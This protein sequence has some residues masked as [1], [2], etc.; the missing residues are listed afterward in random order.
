MN[1]L[2]LYI[3]AA[4]VGI[5]LLLFTC[6]YQVR[7]NEQAI[8]TTFGKAGDNAQVTE[9]GLKFKWP[10]PVQSVVKFD[11]RTKILE[12]RLENV[13]TADNQLVAV[14]VFLAWK[15]DDVLTYF[16]K[17]TNEESAK[18]QLEGR[19]SSAL[20][21]FSQFTFND[22]L[23]VGAANSGMTDVESQILAHLSSG[24]SNIREE[25]GIDPVAVGVTQFVLGE[26]TTTAVFERMKQE[27][28]RVAANARS[29][30][31]AAKVKIEADATTAARKIRSFAERLA[32][33]IRATGSEEAARYLAM[34]AETPE[35]EELAIF[36]RQLEAME[37]SIQRYSTVILP[38]M[39]PFNLLA[40]PP[41]DVNAL[42]R[43]RQRDAETAAA[44][45]PGEDETP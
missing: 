24:Q 7:F 28:E 21:V 8:V 26:A 19:M 39:K 18:R 6:T 31:E 1:R 3:I 45:T 15:I 12:T 16:K 30:G 13:M 20:G 9:P 14:Q 17:V 11:T 38:M 40:E 36:L 5:T 44:I 23:N 10:Y 42:R 33:E 32:E 29:S 4:I 22:L 25:Y 43:S 37:A 34:Q 35:A 2:G 27:R 41:V